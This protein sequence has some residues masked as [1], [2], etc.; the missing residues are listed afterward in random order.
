LNDPEV[1][2][3]ITHELVQSIRLYRNRERT[4][5][6][7]IPASSVRAINHAIDTLPLADARTLAKKIERYD[8]GSFMTIDDVNLLK[9]EKTAYYSDFCTDNKKWVDERYIRINTLLTKSVD[10]RNDLALQTGYLWLVHEVRY[11]ELPSDYCSNNK[12]KN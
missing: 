9:T 2:K 8:L 6:Y 5:Q 4:E 7:L 1:Y 10:G 12:G 11:E 3:L